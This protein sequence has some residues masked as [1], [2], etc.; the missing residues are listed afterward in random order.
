MPKLLIVG[1]VLIVAV[2][3]VGIGLGRRSEPGIDVGRLET[4]C[5]RSAAGLLVAP[6]A[7][8]SVTIPAATGILSFM[9]V[10]KL[11]VTLQ[12]GGPVELHYAPT[13]ASLPNDR[14]PTP[15]TQPLVVLS[16]GVRLSLKC[17]GA[18]CQIGLR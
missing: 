13:P 9:N 18:P 5:R 12:S 6:D 7:P 14:L 4:T 1:L 16:S 11:E 10:R 17:V 2:F 15:T 3:A 8:C